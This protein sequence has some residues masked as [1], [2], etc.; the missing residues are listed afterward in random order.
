MPPKRT[1]ARPKAAARTTGSRRQ[2]SAAAAAAAPTTVV[3]NARPRRAAPR[4]KPP[5]RYAHALVAPFVDGVGMKYPD[6]SCRASATSWTLTSTAV[7]TDSSGNAAFCLSP[8]EALQFT[9]NGTI[10]GG[11][12]TWGTSVGPQN[13]TALAGSSS[14]Y[15][16]VSAGM[17]FIPSVSVTN[18]T[19]LFT[20]TQV[21]TP[22]A[23]AGV[24]PIVNYSNASSAVFIP[25]TD[26]WQAFWK[27]L[28]FE[29]V[30]YK[31]WAAAPAAASPENNITYLV[32]GAPASTTIGRL[33][34]IVNWEVLVDN[35]SSSV[36]VP[37]P[38]LCDLPQLQ[39]AAN[40]TGSLQF[41][42]HVAYMTGAGPGDAESGSAH[43][44]SV[45][46]AATAGSWATSSL[47]GAAA[48][49]AIGVGSAMHVYHMS[50][51]ARHA[52]SDFGSRRLY[53][54]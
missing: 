54:W 4:P 5:S 36:L 9:T 13:V 33:V 12:V 52:I 38:A 39:Y 16:C 23:T 21:T 48:T 28:D 42:T 49:A 26:T 20:V 43:G 32:Q 14:Q 35:G 37:T 40:T 47:L 7:V 27:P 15:R 2:R 34:W 1:P 41:V 22:P 44:D 29:S 10:S 17:M 50:R 31:L 53:G 25:I 3:V 45:G 51:R 6:L 19:G 46:G 30:N 18:G 24:V 11:N 8:S